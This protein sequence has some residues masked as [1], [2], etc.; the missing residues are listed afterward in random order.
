MSILTFSK[1]RVRSGNIILKEYS[2]LLNAGVKILSV[3]FV[4]T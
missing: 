1:E 3:A 4:V 2:N